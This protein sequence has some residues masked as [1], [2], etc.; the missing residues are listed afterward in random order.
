M[1][2][3][4]NGEPFDVAFFTADSKRKKA[5]EYLALKGVRLQPID[6]VHHPNANSDNKRVS[7]VYEEVKTKR[8]SHR[9]ND[10]RNLIV[11]SRNGFFKI[12]PRLME[13]FNGKEVVY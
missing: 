9:A 4:E 3:A 8:P 6:G 10:T 5:G 13:E 7:K 2:I 12:H 1:Q 11:D